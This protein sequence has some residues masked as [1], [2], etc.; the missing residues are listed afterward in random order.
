[1]YINEKYN[2]RLKHDHREQSMKVLIFIYADTE[3]LLEKIDTCHNNTEKSSTTK[4]KKRAASGYSLF[5]HCS[6]YTT[7]INIEVMIA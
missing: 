5:T 2:K 7:K 4:K 3:S 6:L 1:M